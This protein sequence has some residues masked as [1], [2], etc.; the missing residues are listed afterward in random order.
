MNQLLQ[1]GILIISGGL[2]ADLL[3]LLLI[4]WDI[5]GNYWFTSILLCISISLLLVAGSLYVLLMAKSIGYLHG[6]LEL[7]ETP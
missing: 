4:P 3:L 7:E 6:I 5:L 2:V 1:A